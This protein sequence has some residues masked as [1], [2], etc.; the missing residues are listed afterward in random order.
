MTPYILDA[1]F[2]I[3]VHQERYPLDIVPS[4]W[5]KIKELAGEK[6]IISIDKVKQ[7]IY[8]KEDDLKIWC[9]NNLP[10]DFFKDSVNCLPSYVQTVRWAHSK[11]DQYSQQALNTFMDSDVAD[12]R[13]VAY[14]MMH[15]FP[16]VT[17]EVSAPGSKKSIKIPDVCSQFDVRSMTPMAMFRELGVKF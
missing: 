10:A 4:F 6:K 5:L 3:Q 7:E 2:F 17:Y 14:A 12:A 8:K 1:N 16:I 11:A 15:H 13:L 9:H